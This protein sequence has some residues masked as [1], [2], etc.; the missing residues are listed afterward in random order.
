MRRLLDLD[1]R[2]GITLGIFN[3]LILVVGFGVLTLLHFLPGVLVLFKEA[4]VAVAVGPIFLL[5]VERVRKPGVFTVC[6]VAQGFFFMLLGFFTVG[7]AS[8]LGGLA[9]DLVASRARYASPGANI[10]AYV[11]M[12]L[13]YVA[14]TYVPFYFWSES[15]I[16]DLVASGRVGRAFLDFLEASLDWHMGLAIL[17]ANIVGAV[18]GGLLGQRM[19]ERHFRRA[20]IA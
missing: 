9:A 11:V 10:A 18:V 4:V 1:A 2:D 15:F 16:G 20:G 6:G 13:F 3:A 14:G 19:V 17:A 5:L 12:R 7:F 8:V